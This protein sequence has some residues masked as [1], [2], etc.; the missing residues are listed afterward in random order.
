MSSIQLN[1]LS[2]VAKQQ[3]LATEL[4]CFKLFSAIKNRYQHCYLFESS[5]SLPRHQDRYITLGFAPLFTV[6]AGGDKL[7]FRAPAKTLSHIFDREITTEQYSFSVE[8]PYLY[9]KEHFQFNF[10]GKTQQGGLVGYFC[11]ESINYFQKKVT[12]DEHPDFGGFSLGFYDDGLT[13]DVTTGQLNYY[14][15]YRDRKSLVQ[16]HIADLDSSPEQES[17][18]VINYLGDSSTREQFFESVRN[19]IEKIKKGYIYQAEVGFKSKY[20]IKGDKIAIY[21]K[22]REINPSPYMFY[23]K[24]NLKELLGASPEILISSKQRYV[25]TTPTAGT[26]ARSPDAIE[27]RKLAG[28][29]LKDEKELAEHSMLVDMHRNDLAKVCVPGSVR[30]SDLMYLI[31]FNFVQ[32]IVSDISGGLKH[33]CDAYDVLATILPGGVV[34]GAP[35]LEA[36]KVIDQNETE[37]RGPYGGA[38]GRFALNG[39]CDFCLPIRSLFCCGDDCFVQTSAG[40]VADSK[41]ENEYEEVQNKLSGMRQTLESLQQK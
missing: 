23:L 15:F 33:N 3:I 41:P 6:A 40:V 14:S 4:D 20:H 34:A 39:D 25:F 10:E 35:K 13:Y 30:I 29:L 11:Y 27:D 5:S 16:Q 19:T 28:Q 22:L 12:V 9:L 7:T 18:L 38:I 1:W 8:N 24:D 31:K 2:A 26:I 37:P 32:H 17:P 21:Q 36:V